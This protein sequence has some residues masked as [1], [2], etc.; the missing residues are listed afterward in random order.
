MTSESPYWQIVAEMA[1]ESPQALNREQAEDLLSRLDAADAQG[2]Y[3]AAEVLT[4]WA[5]E[6]ALRDYNVVH[7]K[8]HGITCITRDGRRVRKT[9]SYSRPVRASESGDIIGYQLQTW[10]GYSKTKLVELR[11]DLADQGARIADVV[12]S[13][14]LLITAM[15]RHPECTTARDAWEADGHDIAEIDLGDS[16]AA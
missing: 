12:E 14:D 6:G 3:W 4:R 7:K 13:V 1:E 9:T 10:W 8:V 15:D 11:R 2:E 16:R 5:R